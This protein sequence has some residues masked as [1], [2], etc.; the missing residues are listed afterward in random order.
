M[1]GHEVRDFV[2]PVKIQTRRARRKTQGDTR[3]GTDL[4]GRTRTERDGNGKES[5]AGPLKPNP[6]R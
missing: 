1:K 5:W 2:I 6:F 4:A 3:T